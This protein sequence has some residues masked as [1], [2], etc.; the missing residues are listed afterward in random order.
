MEKQNNIID[1][2]DLVEKMRST[3]VSVETETA[4][5]AL[6]SIQGLQ[7]LRLPIISNLLRKF[8]EIV[9]DG[10]SKR[11]TMAAFF[12]NTAIR[13]ASQAS[14]YIEAVNKK[15]TASDEE[16]EQAELDEIKAFNDFVRITN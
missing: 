14:D 3:F 7:W 2:T 16:Y 11:P 9:L 5:Q 15:E 12:G 1:I 10:L 6:A 8:I 13:K 4:F